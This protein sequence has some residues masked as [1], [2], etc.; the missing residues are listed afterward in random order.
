MFQRLVPKAF[1]CL[2]M[3]MKVKLVKR[4]MKLQA[5]QM[6]HKKL[7]SKGLSALRTKVNKNQVNHMNKKK[8]ESF[9]RY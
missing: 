1:A 9:A 7:I 8:A 2:Q 4:K 6:H 3:H 5:I